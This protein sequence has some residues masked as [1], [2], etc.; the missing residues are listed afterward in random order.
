MNFKDECSERTEEM[1]W[2]KYNKGFYD[3]TDEQ[4]DEIW[5]AAEEAV[6]DIRL[7]I[8]E[9]MIDVRR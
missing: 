9:S 2:D 5:S 1:A 7:S 4:Q 6:I 8:A 3:L